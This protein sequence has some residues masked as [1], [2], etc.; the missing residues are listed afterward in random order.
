VKGIGKL[1]S[2][3]YSSRGMSIQRVRMNLIAKNISNA[4]T[5][6]TADGTP[7]KR[8]YL[9]IENTGNTFDT[10]VNNEGLKMKLNTSNKN[11]F[12]GG[13][14]D[15]IVSSK[16]VNPIHYKIEEDSKQGELIFMPN[17]PDADEKGYVEMSN[18][19]II[20]EMVEMISATRN[21]EANLTAFNA[22][23][24]IAK[25]SLEI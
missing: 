22:S 11:H 3:D 10:V 18:V 14:S 9:E 20:T 24:Q 17:H 7:Y 1:N 25:D 21:Y 13:D 2:F 15:N 6:K 5:T 19:N 4:E 12:S 23:K 16:K 8:K